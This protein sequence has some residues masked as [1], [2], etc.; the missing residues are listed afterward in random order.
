MI[1]K[2][3]FPS[4]PGAIELKFTNALLEVKVGDE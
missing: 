1:I 3:Y 2:K 4:I